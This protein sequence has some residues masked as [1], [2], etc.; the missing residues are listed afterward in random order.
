MPYIHRYAY[1]VAICDVNAHQY[2]AF[3]ETRLSGHRNGENGTW[4]CWVAIHH[5]TSELP[6]FRR[7]IINE[8][9]K[10]MPHHITSMSH[11]QPSMT[12]GV[13]VIFG[14]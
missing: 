14:L 5:P 13:V 2:G 1:I 8:L 11:Y 12:L 9:V 3:L 7:G 4:S 10:I 6:C